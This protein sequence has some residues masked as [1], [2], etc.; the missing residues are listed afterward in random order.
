MS[1][2]AQRGHTVTLIS[3]FD[4]LGTRKV[5][6]EACER[7]FRSRDSLKLILEIAFLSDDHV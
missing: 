5:R 3:I 4:S 6:T 7:D 2:Q 1:E